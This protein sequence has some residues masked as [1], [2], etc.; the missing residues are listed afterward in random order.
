MDWW[1]NITFAAGLTA[2][3]AGI[4]YGIQ[5]YGGHTQGW[6]NPWVLAGLIGGAGLLVGFVVIETKV[7]EPLFPMQLFR[8]GAFTG[9]N[10]ATLLGSIARGGL[11]FMLIIWLQGIWLPLHGY[12]YADTPLWAGIYLLPLTLGFLVAG[13]LCGHLSDKFDPHRFAAAGFALMGVSFAGL[14]ML[15][16]DFPYWA[17]A[18]MVFLNGLA[19][20]LYAAPNASIIM[21]SAPADARGAASG[22]R[23][24]FQNAGMVLSIGVF[25]SLLVAGLSSSLPDTLHSG[26]TA[27]GVSASDADAVAAIPPVGVVFSAFLGYNP[28]KELLGD[29]VLNGLPQENADTLTGRLFFPHLISGPFHDGL[30][31]VFTLAIVMSLAAAVLSLIRPKPVT[32]DAGLVTP[33]DSFIP[34]ESVPGPT[35]RVALVHGNIRGPGGTG[36]SAVLHLLDSS[37]VRR[38]WAFSGPDGA[39]TLSAPTPGSYVLVATTPGH[40]PHAATVQ[41][42]PGVLR[43]DATLMWARDADESLDELLLGLNAGVTNNHVL[44]GDPA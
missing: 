37:G 25:F 32:V 21:S 7:A 24:T 41:V 17:F 38:V 3:L 10:S 29:D 16:T 11:Q 42:A 6:T 44:R 22:M 18:L 26:L 4:T 20:G 33:P 34:A 43:H 1:G 5:P 13:P 27:Q 40:R 39:Y 36:V 9:G 31:V 19:G 35:A 8:S 2:F 23:A 14:L 15:P 12:D 30:L 28:I